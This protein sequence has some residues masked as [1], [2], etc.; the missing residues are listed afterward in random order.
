RGTRGG[1][2][3]HVWDAVL[4]PVA[5]AAHVSLAIAIQIRL[6]RVGIV[7]AVI[8]EVSGMVAVPVRLVWVGDP[9]AVVADVAQ[10]IRICV[11][12]NAPRDRDVVEGEGAAQEVV[13]RVVDED[14]LNAPPRAGDDNGLVMGD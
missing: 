1:S 6:A 4:V 5:A 14:Q 3:P 8:A 10:P 7:R 11:E 12:L 2:G 13:D 9:G